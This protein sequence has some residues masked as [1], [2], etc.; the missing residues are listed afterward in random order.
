MV[1]GSVAAFWTHCRAHVLRVRSVRQAYSAEV[2]TKAG[3]ACGLPFDRLRTGRTS[4][5]REGMLC[6][7]PPNGWTLGLPF[8]IPSGIPGALPVYNLTFLANPLSTLLKYKAGP[9]G[10]ALQK[11]CDYLQLRS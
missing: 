5:L 6:E 4:R 1:E 9:S 3:R 10:G 7:Q 2:A 11:S 8:I